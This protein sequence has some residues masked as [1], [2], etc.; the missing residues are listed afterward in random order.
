MNG[1]PGAIL[2]DRDGKVA[3]A[4]SLDVL[5][6]QVQT[7]RSVGNPESWA[8]SVRLRTRGP[9]SASSGGLARTEFAG[10][11]TRV[12]DDVPAGVKDFALH[13]SGGW[14]CRVQ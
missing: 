11:S 8:T 13:R 10:C 6:G 9:F 4:L 5:G 14:V 7:I 1:Q 3:F 12:A 2:R